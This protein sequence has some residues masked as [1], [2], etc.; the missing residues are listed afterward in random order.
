M[1]K[2]VLEVIACSVADA[3]AAECGGADRVEVVRELQSGGLTPDLELVK[4]I[5]NAVDL[6]LRIMLRESIGFETTSEDEIKRLCDAAASFESLGVDGVVIGFLKHGRVDI[7]PTQRILDSAPNVRATFHHA[8]ED[9]TDHCKAIR[10]IKQL[11]Q[12]DRILSHGGPGNLSERAER[13]R[14]YQEHASPELTILAGGGI[15]AA[16]IDEIVRSTTIREFHVGR[17][18]RSL[19]KVEGGVQP[20]LV[21]GLVEVVKKPAV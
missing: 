10:Q 5:K 7:E 4:E 17:A 19:A 12:V 13:L 21:S 3:I 16:A 11:T 18:A 8:F 2:F 15:D 9:T 20:S 6:P 1:S 14:R